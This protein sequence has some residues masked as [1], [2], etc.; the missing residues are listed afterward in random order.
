[1]TL[2][3]GG[4]IAALQRST[5]HT[6][7]QTAV[8]TAVAT[9][10]VGVPGL[11][12]AGLL[13]PL[14]NVVKVPSR[15]TPF[16]FGGGA[17]TYTYTVTNPGV[18]ALNNV[19]VTDN[20]CASVAYIS[21]DANN[22]GLLDTSETW[23]YT[24]STRIATSTM[25]TA[26]AEGTANGLTAVSYAFATVLVAVPGLP[27]TGFPPEGNIIAW[28]ALMVVGLSTGAYFYFTKKKHAAGR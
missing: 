10:V 4:N 28:I 22:N 20:K 13:P 5:G 24:C 7:S 12:N 8:A 3:N 26:T 11:P 25:N 16:P 19:S 2:A 17:V 27:N 15:L 1:L 21:G 23:T 18:V 9:V 6:G 14:I